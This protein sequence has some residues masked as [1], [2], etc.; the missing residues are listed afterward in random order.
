V[1][2]FR[3]GRRRNVP[4]RQLLHYCLPDGWTDRRH[5][6]FATTGPDI[7]FTSR[8]DHSFGGI[9]VRTLLSKFGFV[10]LGLWNY[11]R[12]NSDHCD[13]QNL[14]SSMSKAGISGAMPAGVASP[15]GRRSP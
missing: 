10:V 1:L 2:W 12:L 3:F 6:G 11:C 5:L 7:Q 9:V 14:L 13:F 8:F 4:T 15:S